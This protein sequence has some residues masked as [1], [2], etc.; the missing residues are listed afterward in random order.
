MCQFYGL[1][2][3]EELYGEDIPKTDDESW[4]EGRKAKQRDG[5]AEHA[6]GGDVDDGLSEGHLGVLP[7]ELLVALVRRVTLDAQAHDIALLS[8]EKPGPFG[9]EG[10]RDPESQADHDGDAAFN[11]EEP[12][13]S[14]KTGLF[15]HCLD[16]VGYQPTEGTGKGDSTV[17]HG[18]TLGLLGSGIDGGDQEGK[19]GEEAG[20]EHAEKKA[21]GNALLIGVDKAGPDSDDTPA[22]HGDGKDSV[23][24]PPLDGHNPRD[25][26]ENI[27]RVEQGRQVVELCSDEFQTL[28]KAKHSGIACQ[29]LM[30]VTTPPTWE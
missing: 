10:E 25:F 13:P 8:V 3:P 2:P 23:G 29:C 27:G 5:R 24:S 11:D 18:D 28:F 19:A 14:R 15:A 17:E 6:D 7:L 26:E 12:A 16:A 21:D 20:L 30:L 9:V 4:Q 1:Y 22:D